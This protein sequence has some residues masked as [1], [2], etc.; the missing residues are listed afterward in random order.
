[1]HLFRHVCH[2]IAEVGLHGCWSF[3]VGRDVFALGEP[4]EV[5]LG[6]G[7][8]ARRYTTAAEAGQLLRLHNK[9][10]FRMECARGVWLSENGLK[11]NTGI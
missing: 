1:M 2:F 3:H 7:L 8:F 4:S 9:N 10:L 5:D 11:Q 6:R